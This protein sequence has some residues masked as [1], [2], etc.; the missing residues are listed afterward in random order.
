MFSHTLQRNDADSE[1][2]ALNLAHTVC[3]LWGSFC[4]FKLRILKPSNPWNPI[5]KTNSLGMLALRYNHKVLGLR[6]A[7]NRNGK[8]GIVGRVPPPRHERVLGFTL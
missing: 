7:P 2:R 4:Y 1:N 6:I 3:S 8:H 5:V